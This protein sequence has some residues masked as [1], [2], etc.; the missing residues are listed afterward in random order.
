MCAP[1]ESGDLPAVNVNHE[2][3]FEPVKDVI[4]GLRERV[5][6]LCNQE[7]SKITKQGLPKETFL[8][9]FSLIL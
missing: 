5:E 6:D 4:L 3:S 1:L 8:L 2:A 9:C 7:L